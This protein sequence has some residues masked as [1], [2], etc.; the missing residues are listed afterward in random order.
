MRVL[1]A[2]FAMFFAGAT[3]AT[4]VR[5]ESRVALVIGNASYVNT[6][7]LAQSRQ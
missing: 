2:I 1:W 6:A 7:P 5:A 3:S 4:A